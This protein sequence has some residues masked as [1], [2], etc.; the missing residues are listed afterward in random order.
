MVVV[1]TGIT[2]VAFLL[3]A[4]LKWTYWRRVLLAAAVKQDVA[5]VKK[6]VHLLCGKHGIF[7]V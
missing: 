6:M 4:F 7:N 5:D 3:P 2:A 1:A